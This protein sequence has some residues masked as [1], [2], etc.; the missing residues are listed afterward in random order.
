MTQEEVKIFVNSLPSLNNLGRQCLWKHNIEERSRTLCLVYFNAM[1]TEVY[2]LGRVSH[3]LKATKALRMC[4]GIAV[5][6][7]KTFG[8]RWSC[9]GQS[10][11]P[12]A[13]TPR[14]DPVP[15]V[16]E[17][18]WAPGPVWTGG[19]ISSP[20]GFDPGQSSP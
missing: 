20:P 17:A 13:Y 19:K 15:N 2:Q 10:H 3:F 8:T 16:Q 7:S 6:F 18:G 11:A 1:A 4:R 14:K 5:F 9:R 12:A